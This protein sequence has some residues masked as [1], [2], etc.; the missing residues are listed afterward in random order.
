MNCISYLV[1]GRLEGWKFDQGEKSW[2]KI[3]IVLVEPINFFI[4]A[5]EAEEFHPHNTIDEEQDTNKEKDEASAG[6][7]GGESLDD[8]LC[9]R[10]LIKH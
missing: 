3:I 7:D 9:E 1:H 4:V 5:Q 8:F 2:K 10:D 6:Q